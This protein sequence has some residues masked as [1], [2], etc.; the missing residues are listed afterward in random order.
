MELKPFKEA[1]NQTQV[2]EHTADKDTK[3]PKPKDLTYCIT[4]VAVCVC[5][6]ELDAQ[7]PT[8]TTTSTA[9]QDSV[10]VTFSILSAL[11]LPLI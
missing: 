10:C 3:L 11:G 4:P 8:T 5:A 2:S 9:S 7:L 6:C 1:T